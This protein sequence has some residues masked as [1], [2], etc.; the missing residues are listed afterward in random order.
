[1]GN[2]NGSLGSEDSSSYFYKTSSSIK[3]LTGS[4]YI[5]LSKGAPLHGVLHF[6]T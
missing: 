2:G 3:K 6:V 5:T 4:A 1:V